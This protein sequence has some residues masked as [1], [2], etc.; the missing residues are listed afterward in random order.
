MYVVYNS[1][2]WVSYVQCRRLLGLEDR[3]SDATLSQ[4]TLCG[5]FCGVTTSTVRVP[6][7][8]LKSKMQLQSAGGKVLGFRGAKSSMYTGVID[9][10]ASIIKRQGVAGLYQG[11]LPTLLRQCVGGLAWWPS[12]ELTKPVCIEK[13]GKSMGVVCAGGFSAYI[14]WVA[15]FPF[16]VVKTR[17]QTDAVN[18]KKRMYR[19]TVHCIESIWRKEGWRAFWKGLDIML[20]RSFPTNATGVLA[21]ENVRS[22]LDQ[23]VP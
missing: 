14:Y 7:D 16:D 10:A 2:N 3:S 19:S 5:L 8:V 23:T 6:M 20:V 13:F 12:Y 21:Y 15:I 9:C 17:M 22:A 11:T 1:I 18:P 4:L